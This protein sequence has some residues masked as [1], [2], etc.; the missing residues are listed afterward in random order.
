[1]RLKDG[2]AEKKMYSNVISRSFKVIRVYSVF[3]IPIGYLGAKNC[4]NMKMNHRVMPI[5]ALTLIIQTHLA[6]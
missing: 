5:Y 3:C 1:M 6:Q 2:H 4:E